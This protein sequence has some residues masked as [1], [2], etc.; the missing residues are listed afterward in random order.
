MRPT[1]SQA[2]EA[3]IP[4]W[5]KEWDGGLRLQRVGGNSQDNKNSRCL[6]IRYLPCHTNRLFKW[7]FPLVTAVSFSDLVPSPHIKFFLV[8]ESFSWVCWIMI[9]STQNNP[10]A[11]VELFGVA[12]F[13]PLS[14]FTVWSEA[15]NNPCFFISRMDINIFVK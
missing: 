7:K 13:A 14:Y 4:S 6:V 2:F 3:Y 1:S 15:S 12:Y 10:P 9:A 8:G 5:A 11:K